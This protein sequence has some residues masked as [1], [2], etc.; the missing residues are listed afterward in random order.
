MNMLVTAAGLMRAA[1]SNTLRV[2]H[3][4]PLATVIS[5]LIA[6]GA[7]SSSAWSAAEPQAVQAKSNDDS[8]LA[9]FD[10]GMLKSRGIDPKVADFFGRAPR[11]P[12]G[13]RRVA[14]TVNGR[15]H[16]NVEAHF[17]AEG[18]LCFNQT[19]LDQAQLMTPDKHYKSNDEGCYD[20]VAAYPQTEIMLQPNR[21]EVSLLVSADALRPFSEDV[22]VYQTGGIAGMFNYELL[23]LSTQS[24][25]SSNRY[26]ST[27]TEWGFNAGDWILRSR[28]SYSA[29]NESE[30]FQSLYTYAQ[31]TF[32]HIASTLQVGQINIRDSVFPGAAITGMQLVPEAGLQPKNLG[33][34]TVQG[35]AQSQARVEVR[36]SGA[37]V[38]TS[39]VPSG[40]FTLPNVQLLNSFTDLDVLV[41]ESNG[42]EHRFSVPAA[43]LVQTSLS[44]PGFSMAVG[45]IR[46]F[47]EGA[48]PSPTLVTASSGWLLGQNSSISAGLMMSDNAYRAAAWTLGSKL[49]PATSVNVRNTLTHA[50]EESAKGAQASLS[51]SSSLSQNINASANYTRQSDGFRSLHDTPQAPS[52]SKTNQITRDQY[53]ITLGWND[54]RLGSLTAGYS[55]SNRFDGQTSNYMN[56]SWNK[57]FKHAT[58]SLN[59]SRDLGGRTGGGN[60]AERPDNAGERNTA[61]YLTISVPLGGSRSVS[62]FASTRDGNT[63]FGTTFQD[64]SSDFASY[65]LSTERDAL[66]QQSFSGDVNIL[67]RFAQATLGYSRNGPDSSSYS[68]QLRGGGSP[69]W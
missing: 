31:K 63:R 4:T 9:S 43:A 48:M 57:S 52:H 56:A 61:M 2:Q 22:N 65:R 20:F 41:V 30:R 6:C 24:F 33:G 54:A 16:G 17:D 60:D 7:G 69:S 40:P 23:G 68:G 59:L 34:A 12:E 21:E 38:H 64:Y 44:A 51:V 14:L 25:D 28:Q 53:G 32:A 19:L 13:S 27:N 62:S 8:A 55:R 39:L 5:T 46:T 10:V 36:Q 42:E 35:I 67:P 58:V 47:G 15:T 1:A 29:Q 26:Y 3:L 49:G 66:Q 18:H 50:G 37:L 11:F 45:E